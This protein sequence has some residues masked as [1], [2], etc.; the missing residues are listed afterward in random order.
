[1][2]AGHTRRLDIRG[3]GACAGRRHGRVPWP[4]F[5][6]HVAL[7][8]TASPP[9]H[10]TRGCRPHRCR[11]EGLRRDAA[12]GGESQV[13]GTTRGGGS[14]RTCIRL[15][16]RS[17]APPP[18]F[19]RAPRPPPYITASPKNSKC[20]ASTC[21]VFS[22][23]RPAARG[24]GTQLRVTRP[25]R[26]HSPGQRT[27]QHY[28]EA[29]LAQHDKYL[30]IINQ[31]EVVIQKAEQPEGCGGATAAWPCVRLCRCREAPHTVA[32]IRACG[33]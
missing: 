31:A 4:D 2:P 5:E 25:P 17:Q 3:L 8:S 1:M 10:A 20:V 22:R 28:P 19:H 6:A 21:W 33:A 16:P 24:G 12:R 14:A 9:C 29:T 30:A 11:G 18:G 27:C 32:S 13:A 15:P 7:K 26:T 23:T